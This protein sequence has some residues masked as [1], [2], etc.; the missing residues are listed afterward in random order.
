MSKRKQQIADI[1]DLPVHRGKE[2]QVKISNFID[3]EEAMKLIFYLHCPQKFKNQQG[4]SIHIKCK[5]ARSV[6]LNGN[7]GFMVF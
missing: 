3:A 6:L 1:L 2:Q 5:H 7:F 4:L